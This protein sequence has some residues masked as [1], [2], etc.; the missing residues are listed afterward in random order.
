MKEKIT[1][2]DNTTILNRYVDKWSQADYIT[3]DTEFIREKTYWPQLC[4]IQIGGPEESV[5]IDPQAKGI[6]LSKL[7]SLLNSSSV[8]KVFHAARQ[9]I[10]LFYHLTG[11][12]P[13]PLFDTQIAAAV[14]GFGDSVGYEK[15]ANKLAG[16]KIDK[17]LRFTDWARR[18]L[19]E[20]Q[21]NYAL[22]DVS[23]LRVVFEKLDAQL[24]ASGR[25]AWL[26]QDMDNLTNTNIYE[27]PP[28]SAWKRIKT[29]GGNKRFY[30]VLR[31]IAAWR[32]NEAKSRNL[33]RGHVVR[34]EALIEIA[35]Q[36]PLNV[37]E[38]N[39]I[40]ALTKR[41]A[42]GK[43]GESLIQ[44][45]NRALNL[46]ENKLPSPPPRKETPPGIGP[47][48]DLLKVLLKSQCEKSGVAQRIVANTNDLE[49]IASLSNDV[50]EESIKDIPALNGWRRNIFGELALALKMGRIS[51]TATKGRIHIISLDNIKLKP[52]TSYED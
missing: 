21:L 3:V 25:R 34:D 46:A 39:G 29:R 41:T 42:E 51:L 17:T 13:Q 35:A 5:I 12:I 52:P 16:E 6:E 4:L 36:K 19:T 44:C 24:S 31:E 11:K 47:I 23:H 45:V 40:R 22:S 1:I 30:G 8:L 49:R 9:D 50:I 43:F 14:C 38:L 32:E 10:E 27:M 7:F 26:D 28:S 33:P 20:Q 48:V 18:P 15:L 37:K 2:I